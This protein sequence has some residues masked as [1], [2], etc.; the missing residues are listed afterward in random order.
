M[1]FKLYAEDTQFYIV[2]TTIQD[3]LNKIEERMTHD[4]RN[5]MIKKKWKLNE[6]KTECMLFD[7]K[8]VLKNH[9][10]LQYV[11]IG[12]SNIKIVTVVHNLGVFIDKNL[13]MKNQILNLVKICH[14][15]HRNTAFIRKY[16]N[17]DTLK[18]IQ[19]YNVKA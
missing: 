1:Q 19:S 14:H 10:Q 5:W 6:N 17:E 4:I 12:S 2:I 7:N 13:T 9:E 15:H 18:N 3:T 16:L 8:Y 11:R